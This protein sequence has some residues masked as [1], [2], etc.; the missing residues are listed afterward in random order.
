M[1]SDAFS[2]FGACDPDYSTHE[3]TVA[4]ATTF[5]MD[6]VISQFISDLETGVEVV[7]TCADFVCL[8]HKR[9]IIYQIILNPQELI[10]GTW[11]QFAL[12]WV[13]Y[14]ELCAMSKSLQEQQRIFSETNSGIIL[15]RILSTL[16]HG[17]SRNFWVFHRHLSI[18]ILIY[19]G[20]PQ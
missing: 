16:L 14:R 11:V 5:M 10:C 2:R 4:E 8:L 3:V 1:N 7:L 12:G 6:T 19:F 9:G 18:W 13:E 15:E 20:T 17:L